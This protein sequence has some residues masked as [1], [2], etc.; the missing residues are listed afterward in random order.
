MNR[1]TQLTLLVTRHCKTDWNQH[2]KLSGHH[3]EPTLVPY[4]EAMSLGVGEICCDALG[5]T[6][7]P[8]TRIYTSDL[9]RAQQ[10]AEGILAGA[11]TYDS[12]RCV[13]T[14]IHPDARLRELNVGWATGLTQAEKRAQL[15]N[16]CFATREPG[17]DF[18]S[19]EGESEA[20]VLERH[21]AFF[22]DVAAWAFEESLWDQAVVIVGHGTS[23][24]SVLRANR[25]PED[26]LAEQG[27]VVKLRLVARQAEDGAVA[28]GLIQI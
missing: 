11:L 12:R 13:R 1:R 8:I 28:Y 25:L 5:L 3:D 9:R 7:V 14:S 24:R 22:R 19:I 21:D 27:K 26:A 18:R 16:P 6:K 20:A 15:T 23:L 2:D 4:G 17:Y 10:T